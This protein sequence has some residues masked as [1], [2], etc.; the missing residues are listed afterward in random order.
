MST[1]RRLVRVVDAQPG[2]DGAGVKIR[3]LAGREL[4][5]VMD[6]FLMLDEI[7]S[8]D[9]ADYIGGFPS[10]PH[11]GFETIT[12][13]LQ[14]KM[15]HADHLGNDGL[16]QSG[17]VQW[18]LAGRG[19]I[20]SEMPEQSEGLMHGFQ[21]WLN[22]PATQKMQPPAY[23]DLRSD[24]LP[25]A[26]L[27]SGAVVKLLLGKTRLGDRCLQAPVERPDT[28]PVIM[29]VQLAADASLEWPC[30]EDATVI[31]YVFQ[32]ALPGL[33]SGQLGVFAQGDVL[34]LQAG[35]QAVR[36]L[37]VAG[38]PLREPIAQ[39][40]PFVMNSVEEIEQALLDYNNGALVE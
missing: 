29:D 10:H 1:Q 38:I 13:M 22:L 6:P 33:K 4:Q 24:E 40:G 14:G 27:D 37:V 34:R 5:R 2:A 35:E 19:V 12:Y 16:L 7:R 32:G 15:R 28:A 39:Y 11:R 8:D 18:M 23:R 20:H 25:Q 26:E 36:L 31:V 3:R 21:L 30:G 17:D 9:S